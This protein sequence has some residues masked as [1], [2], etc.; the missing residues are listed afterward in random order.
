MTLTQ[1]QTTHILKSAVSTRQLPASLPW[2]TQR[3]TDLFS[4]RSGTSSCH[5]ELVMMTSWTPPMLGYVAPLL[6]QPRWHCSALGRED[7]R[8]SDC[9]LISSTV[10]QVQQHMESVLYLLSTEPLRIEEILQP[11]WNKHSECP[12][13]LVNHHHS[14]DPDQLQETSHIKAWK[15]QPWSRLKLMPLHW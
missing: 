4:R 2:Q 6:P 9:W 13:N 15:F 11:A 7:L 12:W 14:S 8:Y 5:W 1:T 10:F 3:L